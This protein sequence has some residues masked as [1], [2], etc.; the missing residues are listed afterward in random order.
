MSRNNTPQ[1]LLLQRYREANALDEARP[2]PGLREAV[3]AQA[4]EQAKRAR[5]GAGQHDQTVASPQTP[6]A[7]APRWHLRALGSLAVLGLAGL[8]FLQFD[9][10]TPQERDLAF[11]APPAASSASAPLHKSAP[12]AVTAAPDTAAAAN[13][14]TDTPS[15]R[16]ATAPPAAPAGSA[17]PSSAPAPVTPAPPEPPP[18]PPAASGAP[19]PPAHIQERQ[20]ARARSEA[21]AAPRAA[22]MPAPATD[23]MRNGGSADMARSAPDSAAVPRL[24]AAAKSGDLAQVRTAIDEGDDLNEV[25]EQG[26]T[27]L[28]HAAQRGDANM[29][30]LLLEAGANATLKDRNGLSAAELARRSG[31]EAVADLL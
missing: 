5:S 19:T 17:P 2:A 9:R 13:A 25:D 15:R 22:P 1:D 11:G 26:R 14:H 30:K 27:A 20:A 6:A 8:L 31:H 10:G 29:V 23:A 18:V 7:N 28:M 16:A 4:R 3:L 24:I 21:P 12:E